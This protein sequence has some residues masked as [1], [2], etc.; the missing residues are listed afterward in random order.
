[1]KII[2][3]VTYYNSNNFGAMLQ[4]YALKTEIEK[5]NCKCLIVSHNRF[6]SKVTETFVPHGFL[7][8]LKKRILFG[9]KYPRSFVL[10]FSSFSNNI[11]NEKRKAKI[12]C[13]TFREQFFQN[14]TETFYYT[15]QQIKQDP[16]MCD[17]YVCGSDQIWNPERIEGA[18]PFFLAF[19]P[20]GRNR[21][22]YAPSIAM[23]YIPDNLKERYK[24]LIVPFSDISVRE[25]NGCKA[26]K[27][28][29]GI[30]PVW[31]MDPTFLLSK[32]EWESFSDV[33][34]NIKRKYLFCYF[35]GKENLLRARVVINKIASAL[36]A[37]VIVMPYGEHVVDRSWKS[38]KNCGPREFVALINNAE[39]V[40]TDSFH[41]TALSILLGKNFNV[42]S[43]KYVAS[44]ANRFD[45]INNILNITKLVSRK[46]TDDADIDFTAINYGIVNDSLLPM[47]EQS[48]SFLKQALEKVIEQKESNKVVPLLAS[49]ESCTGCSACAASCPC[50]AITMKKDNAGFWMP[51]IDSIRCIHCGK[52]ENTCP[53]RNPILKKR[54]D[55]GYVALYTKDEEL[56]YKGSSGNAFGVFALEMLNQNGVVFGAAFTDNDFRKLQITSTEEIEL[57]KLQ[58][59]KYLEAEM[60]DVIKRIET[61]LLKEKKQVLFTG[62][63]C[64]SAGLRKYFG[65]HPN[66]LI[67]DFICHGVPS[68]QWFSKYLDEME[69]IYE[70]KVAN[71]EFRSKALGWRLY[72]MKID[73]IN[74]KHYLKSQYSDPYFIDF[75]Y[76]KHLRTSCYSCNRVINSYADITFGDYWAVNKKHKINDT[77]KGISIVCLRTD[78]G[79][80]FFSQ[81]KKHYKNLFIYPLTEDDVDETFV[82]RDRKIPNRHDN[83]PEHFDMNPQ[84]GLK[85][86]LH[87]WLEYYYQFKLG[88][89]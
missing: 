42:Y 87:R 27:D 52:C 86:R 31:V 38:Y 37:I 29:T 36:N 9:F 26:I 13:S 6:E 16:P 51:I 59:S 73:F 28:A 79:K 53:I 41:G 62:T 78:K 82:Y 10:L 68:S 69:R 60:G 18:E 40:L 57:N 46:F 15:F 22:A 8:K 17:A 44:F 63:P 25:K 12:K 64:Q 70:T 67:C 65:N 32:V 66:L 75:L 23:T 71:V 14:R 43:G 72:C 30:Q 58:K 4:A 74:G 35:L 83:L 50:K 48:K 49:K 77:D 39:H 34:L 76:N 24:K 21:I 55:I 80:K 3:L 7:N 85:G 2:G 88:K 45:R 61:L 54:H 56:R 5:N 19:A 47:I 84:L 33:N 11:R 81:V 1:M 20:K 89:K